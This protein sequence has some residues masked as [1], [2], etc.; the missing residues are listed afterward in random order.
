MFMLLF[1]CGDHGFALDSQSVVEIFPKVKLKKVPQAPD[2]LAGLLN[3]GGTH[4]PVIDICQVI[5]KRPSSA[6]MHTRLI[7]VEASPNQRIAI[8]AEKVTETIEL[9]EAQFIDSGLH[10]EGL[11]FLKGV[12]SGEDRAIQLFD[13]PLFCQSLPSLVAY[14]IR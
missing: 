12:Y 10:V 6:S 8:L 4:I 9:E 1:Y 3:Y 11:P 14:G 13:L 5:E 2:Y 7:L